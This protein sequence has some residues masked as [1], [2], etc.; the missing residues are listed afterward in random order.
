MT[1]QEQMDAALKQ[2]EADRKAKEDMQFILRGLIRDAETLQERYATE[3]FRNFITRA[4]EADF[5]LS[6]ELMPR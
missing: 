5:W 3:D 4:R 1:T 6:K 2:H